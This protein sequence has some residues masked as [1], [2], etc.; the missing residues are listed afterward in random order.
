MARY[1]LLA[2]QHVQA[3]PD[4]QPTD[5]QRDESRRTGVRPRPP[6]RV[7]NAGQVVVSDSDLVA[8]FGAEKFQ[9]LGPSR[10]QRTTAFPGNPMPGDPVPDVGRTSPSA[11]PHGQ[12]STGFQGAETG[13]DV[14]HP[15]HPITAEE[16]GAAEAHAG[17]DDPP[18]RDFDQE[19]GSLDA[20]TVKD[21]KELA[22]EE[23]IDLKGCTH[24]DEIVA[25]IREAGR[26]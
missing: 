16:A 11:A 2:G 5:G 8:K 4:W 15:S 7:Y 3:D 9:L 12:V 19:Y 13:G 17:E 18:A 1:K 20:M 22:A 21:L 14:E 25:A 23:E 24:K 26:R 10:G 6:S